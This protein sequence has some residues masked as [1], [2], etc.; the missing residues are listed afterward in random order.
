MMDEGEQSGSIGR[1]QTERKL[2]RAVR[3][4][5]TLRELMEGWVSPRQARFESVLEL[6]RRLLPVELREHC[7]IAGISGGQLKVRVG[8]SSYMYE[9]QLCSSELLKQFQRQCPQARIKKI[10][11]EVGE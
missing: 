6:W 1:W 2:G 4:G 9:L 8:L 7:K 3:L 10:K 11:F 5:D